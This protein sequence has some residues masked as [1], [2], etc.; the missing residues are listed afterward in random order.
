ME[1]YNKVDNYIKIKYLNIFPSVESF[2]NV[3]KY[4]K[5]QFY[6]VKLHHQHIESLRALSL[7]TD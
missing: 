3:I 6:K 1:N 5:P 7:L 2:L 4:R